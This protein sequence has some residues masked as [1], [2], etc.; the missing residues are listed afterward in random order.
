MSD[1][2]V[3]RLRAAPPQGWAAERPAADVL[4][5]RR[6]AT[7]DRRDGEP[8]AERV[9]VRPSGTEP[10]LKAYLQVVMPPDDDVAAARS[11]ART[12]MAALRAEVA[13]LLHPTA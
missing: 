1:A 4:V 9:V 7:G 8:L 13:E 2:A 5:L 6:D 12:R 3:E 10:K 11:V